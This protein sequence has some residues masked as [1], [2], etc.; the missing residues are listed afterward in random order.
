MTGIDETIAE[1]AGA[2]GKLKKEAVA[3]CSAVFLAGRVVVVVVLRSG[4]R[5][6]ESKVLGCSS[7][8]LEFSAVT[9]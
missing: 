7:S 8:A 9:S 1:G 3:G 5:K 2:R 4:Y 6:E